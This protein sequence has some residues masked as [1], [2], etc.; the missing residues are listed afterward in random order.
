MIAVVVVG[1]KIIVCVTCIRAALS[2]EEGSK[3]E[4][5]Q[6]S[7]ANKSSRSSSSCD[8]GSS[9][10]DFSGGYGTGVETKSGG[11][12]GNSGSIVSSSTAN[13]SSSCGRGCGGSSR[14]AALVVLGASV[15]YLEK[16]FGREREHKRE[17]E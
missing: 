13:R 14:N 2:S 5:S 10:S 4:N 1:G 15:G 9:G 12:G 7:L 8:S 11:G 6:L 16:E 3:M 17:R